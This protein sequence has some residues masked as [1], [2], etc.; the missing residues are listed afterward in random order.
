[1]S[2]AKVEVEA[3]IMEDQQLPEFVKEKILTEVEHIGEQESLQSVPDLARIAAEV[4]APEAMLPHLEQLSAQISSIFRSH[5]ARAFRDVFPL[6][7][8]VVGFG[9][10]PALLLGRLRGAPG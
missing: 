10:I 6:A 1:V 2:E 9:I 7:G 4:G 3:V 8:I 5:M